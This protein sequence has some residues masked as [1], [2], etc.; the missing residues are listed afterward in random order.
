MAAPKDDVDNARDRRRVHPS[1]GRSTSSTARSRYRVLAYREAAK[2]IRQSPVSIAEL[3]RAGRVTELPGIGK[4]IEEKIVA[5][6][7]TGSIPSADKLKAKFPPS[8]VEV[9]LI[10]GLGAKTV[11]RLLRRA[12]HRDARR[13]A[14][15][16]RR[17][18]RIRG[19]QGARPEGRGEHRRAAREARR[20]GAVG[21]RAALRRAA[22]GRAAGRGPARAPG[23][24]TR[25]TS[26]APPGAW[27]RPARTST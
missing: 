13:P 20:R 16:D 14:R 27:P 7:E 24:A 25:S 18:E 4:T 21:A 23:L 5:L 8:L 2:V 3:T 1:S 10:P 15:G 19:A 12:R 6:L 26:P 17:A 9:T 22:G 11:R